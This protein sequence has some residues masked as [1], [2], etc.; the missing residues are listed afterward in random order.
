MRLEADMHRNLAARAG[1]WSA[2]HWKTAT[3]GWLL[4]VVAAVAAGTIAGTKQLTD[5]ES[6]NGET[7]RAE[8]ILAHAGFD[9]SATEAD[10]GERG[11]GRPAGVAGDVATPLRAG[12]C[13][14]RQGAGAVAG[15]Q[16]AARAVRSQG[17][18]DTADTA[19]SRCSMPSPPCRRRIRG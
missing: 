15:R 11:A 17:D 5:A 4:V 18:G 12:G 6:S 14:E 3:F 13:E 10:P 19:S 1:R 7:A 8:R 2:A 16:V 9:R